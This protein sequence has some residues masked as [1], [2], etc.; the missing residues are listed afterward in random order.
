MELRQIKHEFKACEPSPKHTIYSVIIL[1][2]RNSSGAS[3]EITPL[4][5]QLQ[6]LLFRNDGDV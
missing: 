1:I 2:N 4:P 3:F 6:K 5:Q